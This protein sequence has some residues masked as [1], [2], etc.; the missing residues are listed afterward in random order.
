MNLSNQKVKKLVENKDYEGLKLIL[1]NNPNL[2]NKRIT[3]PF[4]KVSKAT[5]HPLHRI[6]DGVNAGKITEAEAIKLAKIFLEHGANIDGDKIDKEG[7]PLLAAASLRAE[8]V[9]IFYIEKGADIH[10]TY[11]NDGVSPL[12]WAAFCGL[13]K[14]VEKLIQ[15]NASI[16]KPDNTYKSTPLSWAI[17][18]LQ[19]NDIHKIHHQVDCIKLLL[20]SG[21]DTKKLSK[22]KNDY[23]ISLCSI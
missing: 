19:M 13:D 2:V 15:S 18:C 17:H 6:C 9:G 21:A 8:K 12:H 14:L 4:N 22:E 16:D 7:T 5:A 23:L 3:I 1:A 10:Y 20:N 11:K